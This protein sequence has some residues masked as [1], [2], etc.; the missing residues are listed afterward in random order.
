MDEI[1]FWAKIHY[2]KTKSKAF[3]PVDTLLSEVCLNTLAS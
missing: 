2:R 3:E 1:L